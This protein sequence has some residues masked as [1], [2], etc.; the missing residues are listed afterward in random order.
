M[1]LPDNEIKFQVQLA[2]ASSDLKVKNFDQFVFRRF[3]VSN[4]FN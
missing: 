2:I 4:I 1:C 3:L